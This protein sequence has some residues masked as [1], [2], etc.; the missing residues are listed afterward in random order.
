[1]AESAG[2]RR[3]L[4]VCCDGTWNKPDREGHTTN[5]VRLVR[6]VKPETA[7]GIAQIV[8]YHSGVGTGNFVDR[9]AGG[10]TGIGLSANV[11]SAYAFIIDNYLDGDEI[12][13]FGFSRGAYTARSVAGL[14]GHVGLLRKRDM[15]NFDEVWDYYRLPTD[16]RDTLENSFLANFPDRVARDQLRIRCIGVWDT[17]GA[18]GIPNSGFCSSEFQFHDTNLSPRVDFAFQALAIDEQR[19]PFIP[20]IW[21]TQLTPGQVVEQVWFAGVHSNIG[22]GYLEHELSDIA[23]FWM[24]SRISPLLEF[25]FDYIAAQAYRGRPYSTGKLQDS[26]TW[27]WRLLLHRR[28][29]RKICETDD[30][31]RIHESVWMRAYDVNGKPDPAPYRDDAFKA[32]L[33]ANEN[34]KAPI[35]ADEQKIL[36]L[37]QSTL[38]EKILPREFGRLSFCDRLVTALGGS[39]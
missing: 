14:I 39:G 11:R 18:L 20:A 22:G 8:Y 37:M 30:T 1:M 3:R 7:D 6:A 36:G 15:C 12:F 28:R 32:F 17:V 38:P 19:A 5:V 4:V 21:K 2:V 27:A 33:K 16:K 29:N 25:D 24:V 23:F 10:S 13:L 31:E 9:L 34:R 26:F 35:S